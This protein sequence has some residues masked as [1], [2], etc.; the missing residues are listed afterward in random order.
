[1]IEELKMDIEFPIRI[2]E[3]DFIRPLGKGSFGYVGLY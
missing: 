2:L 3:Y 1:M